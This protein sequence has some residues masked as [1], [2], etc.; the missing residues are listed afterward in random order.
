LASTDRSFVDRRQDSCG[1]VVGRIL[2]VS[3][4]PFEILLVDGCEKFTTALRDVLREQN[5]Q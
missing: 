2:S 5:A 4:D 1:R 3:D